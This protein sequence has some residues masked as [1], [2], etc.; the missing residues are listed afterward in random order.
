MKN[1]LLYLTVS[2][3][4][5]PSAFYNLLGFA[6]GKKQEQI[7]RFHFDIDKK[8]S[9]YADLLIRIIAC[10]TLSI[11]N[12]EIEFEKEEYGKPY[13]K[14]N[15]QFHYNISHTKNAIA[16]AIS[17][18]PIGVDIEKIKKAELDIA[19]R[20]FTANEQNYI[21]KN[22]NKSDKRFYEIWTEK[23]AYIKYIGKGLSIPLNS[24]NVF[25]NI[26][27]NRILT[28]EK[29]EY[30]ISVCCEKLNIQI[31]DIS[32]NELEGMSEQWLRS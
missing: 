15:P 20:F 24:F 13:I 11:K 4:I 29:D 27:S 14:G 1:K 12:S 3:L 2:E 23:E 22:K 7:K 6:S 8:L 17:D 26:I 10:Q 30:I 25:E 16:I 19:N 21:N 31:Q 9:L 32:E 5:E 18:Y 28:F